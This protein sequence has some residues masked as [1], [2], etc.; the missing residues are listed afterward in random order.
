MSVKLPLIHSYP[1]SLLSLCVIILLLLWCNKISFVETTLSSSL[2]SQWK[3]TADII[4]RD[5]SIHEPSFI[6]VGFMRLA[7]E[8][9]ESKFGFP[10]L[11]IY[12]LRRR[13]N[14]ASWR[15]Q[16]KKV[17]NYLVSTRFEFWRRRSQILLTRSTVSP[18]SPSG[19][20]VNRCFTFFSFLPFTRSIHVIR[21]LINYDVY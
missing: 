17:I 2:S 10:P 1:L 11:V 4:S 7:P 12:F 3:N 20:L 13:F 8:A 14:K 16:Y 5:K 6:H 19:A 15:W 9:N 18:P 21:T